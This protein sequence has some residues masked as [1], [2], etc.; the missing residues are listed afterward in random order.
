MMLSPVLRFCNWP[1][2]EPSWSSCSLSRGTMGG[3]GSVTFSSGPCF[4]NEDSSRCPPCAIQGFATCPMDAQDLSKSVGPTGTQIILF[5]GR[6]VLFW[7]NLLIVTT[8]CA[9]FHIKGGL[10]IHKLVFFWMV[11]CKNTLSSVKISVVHFPFRLDL[12]DLLPAPSAL[13]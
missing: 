7:S 2:W 6:N 11:S 9:A 10:K 3:C 8:Y 5:S 1:G 13:P 4:R 12:L